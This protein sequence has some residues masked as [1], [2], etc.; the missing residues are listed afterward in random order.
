MVCA[1]LTASRISS[2]WYGVYEHLARRIGRMGA[3]VAVG[4]R[5]LTVVYYMLKRNQPYDEDYEQRRLAEQ[6]A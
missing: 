1:A 2:R 4:R 5:L 3:R 6:G